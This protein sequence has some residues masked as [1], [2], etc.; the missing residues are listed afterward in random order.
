MTDE[1]IIKA[2]EYCSEDDFCVSQCPFFESTH[3]DKTQ[4][5]RFALDLINRQKAEI[6]RLTK[7]LEKVIKE[8]T[9]NAT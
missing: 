7:L 5:A 4:I 2:L 6:E 8:K 1:Q 9:K 3:C